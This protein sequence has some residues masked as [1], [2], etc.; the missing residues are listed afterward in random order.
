MFSLICIFTGVS[1]LVLHLEFV[2]WELPFI[3]GLDFFGDGDDFIFLGFGGTAGLLGL[4]KELADL[5]TNTKNKISQNDAFMVKERGSFKSPNNYVI[6][7][8]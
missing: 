6:K 4:F 1:P 5:Q 7:D 3:S 8:N 2:K